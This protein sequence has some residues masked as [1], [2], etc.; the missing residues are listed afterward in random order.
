MDRQTFIGTLADG[1][2]AA[3]L[4]AGA[5]PAG[6]VQRIGLLNEGAPDLPS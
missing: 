4:A 5:Q 6:K 2:L 3:P 1:L